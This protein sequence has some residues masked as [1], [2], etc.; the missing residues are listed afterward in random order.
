M[1][2]NDKWDRKSFGM[3]KHAYLLKLFE[4]Y[5]DDDKEK[6]IAEIE[7]IAEDW[8]VMSMR[9]LKENEQPKTF[10]DE[11]DKKEIKDLF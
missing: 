6:T 3:C 1:D 8:A 11:I 4:K 9:I 7:K 10:L 2:L 5:L